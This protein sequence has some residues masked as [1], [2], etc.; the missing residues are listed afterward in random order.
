MEAAREA[1]TR[2]RG[3]AVAYLEAD[4]KHGL[5]FAAHEATADALLAALH[6]RVGDL[7]AACAFA[8]AGMAREPEGLLLE[9]LRFL[10]MRDARIGLWSH[11]RCWIVR[12]FLRCAAAA[13]GL[14]RRHVVVRHVERLLRCGPRD[15]LNTAAEL[16]TASIAW[17]PLRA[18][19]LWWEDDES[20]RDLCRCG[21]PAVG[22]R[23]AAFRYDGP[24]FRRARVCRIGGSDR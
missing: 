23:E 6:R 7:D 4:R 5:T 1:A 17:G 12:A 13:V 15:R 10:R 22:S 16:P 24:A 9:V 11:A 21:I 20:I 3:L 14:G 2:W 19:F 8:R 18:L